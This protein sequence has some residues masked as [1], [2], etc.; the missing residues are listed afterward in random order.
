MTADD[1]SRGRPETFPGDATGPRAEAGASLTEQVGRLARDL[2]AHRWLAQRGDALA[3]AAALAAAHGALALA[4]APLCS[5]AERGSRRAA[6]DGAVPALARCRPGPHRRPG[7]RGLRAGAASGR[8]DAQLGEAAVSRGAPTGD[9]GP[10]AADRGRYAA[11]LAAAADPERVFA[12]LLR[13]FERLRV[14]V[15]AGDPADGALVA[16]ELE[17]HCLQLCVAPPASAVAADHRRR[18]AQVIIGWAWPRRPALAAVLEAA[19]AA[20]DAAL[21]RRG[22]RRGVRSN[23]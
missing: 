20:G 21:G 23:R 13:A 15:C 9:G 3:L 18:V 4:T 22:R 17:L 11:A 19:I 8:R 1:P 6:L 2:A 16:R 12:L 7:R 10:S 14:A 5:P